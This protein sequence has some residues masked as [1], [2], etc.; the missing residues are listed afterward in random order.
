[1]SVRTRVRSSSRSARPRLLGAA[2]GLAGLVLLSG[3][4]SAPSDDGGSATTAAHC[5]RMV[6]NSG[7]L[8]DRS[9]T[10]VWPA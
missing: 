4:A 9:F 5:A 6:T 8:E 2:A 7:G 1:M 3:C 10:H